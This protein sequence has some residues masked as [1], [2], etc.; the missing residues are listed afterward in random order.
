MLIFIFKWTCCKLKFDLCELS[1]RDHISTAW[2]SCVK[3]SITSSSNFKQLFYHSCWFNSTCKL[4]AVLWVS[5][6][7]HSHS[8]CCSD[9][10]CLAVLSGSWIGGSQLGFGGLSSMKGA[11]NFAATG[12]EINGWKSLWEPTW[13]QAGLSSS[14]QCSLSHFSSWTNE[15][16]WIRMVWIRLVYQT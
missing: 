13:I 8:K 16:E 11:V 2:L 6:P 14:S 15:R 7:L 1:F 9:K 10:F 3:I 5:S 12:F 4:T